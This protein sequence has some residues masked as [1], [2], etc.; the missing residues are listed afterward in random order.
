MAVI[1]RFKEKNKDIFMTFSGRVIKTL[2][3]LVQ[4]LLNLAGAVI[5]IT[6]LFYILMASN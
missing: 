6:L 1:G 2:L 3:N 4:T 5:F